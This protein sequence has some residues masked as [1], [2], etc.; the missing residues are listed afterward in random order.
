MWQS[1]HVTAAAA[2]ATGVTGRLAFKLL[3]D[4]MH[5]SYI[6]YSFTVTN[7]LANIGQIYGFFSCTLCE[8][9]IL[10]MLKPI[11]L[12]KCSSNV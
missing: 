2:L 11:N 5:L 10:N 9:I 1:G 3:H 4:Q 7:K 6:R 12:G 8:K